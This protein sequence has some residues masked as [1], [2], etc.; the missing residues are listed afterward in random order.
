[1]SCAV[2]TDPAQMAFSCGSLDLKVP[3][4][5]CAVAEALSMTL[6]PAAPAAKR[7][8]FAARTYMS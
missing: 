4:A 6:M 5:A 7:R 3:A 1:M 8:S 2:H